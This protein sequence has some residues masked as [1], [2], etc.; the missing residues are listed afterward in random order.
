MHTLI[1][2]LIFFL[3]SAIGSFISVLNYRIKKKEKGI[4]LGHSKCP[5]CKKNLKWYDLIPLFSYIFLRGKCRL[6][7]KKIEIRYFF[8]ELITGLVFVAVFLKYPF[9]IEPSVFSITPI[10][11]L[12]TLFSFIY[13]AIIGAILIAIFFYD[14]DTKQIPDLFL[15]VLG[16]ITVSGGIILYQND[17]L[18]VLLAVG[19]ALFFFGGQ[20][21]VSKGEWL[22]EGDF[23]LSL[24]MAILLGWQLFIL[25][26]VAT[27]F[28]GAAASIPLLITKSAKLKS[29]IPFAPFMITGY[30]ITFFFGNQ[31]IE[32]YLHL[33]II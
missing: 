17:I 16:I 26:I 33:T 4:I 21:V 7:K 25:F 5:H 1:A 31:L 2:F 24:S 27:Y 19:I 18:N 3:G 8:L 23:Y 32:W 12:W 13:H 14:L 20:I 22:G 9:I 28:I 10:L 30:L 29:A 6:C 11:D 15:I